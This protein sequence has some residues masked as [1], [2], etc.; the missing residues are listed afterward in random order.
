M[1]FGVDSVIDVNKDV[2][3][4]G[5]ETNVLQ[6]HSTNDTALSGVL[7][8]TARLFK[9]LRIDKEITLRET[10]FQPLLNDEQ[11]K[12]VQALLFWPFLSKLCHMYR[13]LV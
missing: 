4:V 9:N 8:D 10:Q 13:T 1:L 6:K 5:I 3:I 11:R 12:F 7:D 2:F